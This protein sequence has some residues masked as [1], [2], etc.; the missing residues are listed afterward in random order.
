MLPTPHDRQAESESVQ[1][2]ITAMIREAETQAALV[3]AFLHDSGFKPRGK[4]R[5]TSLVTKIPAGPAADFLLELG[6]ALRLRT[7]EQAGLRSA[8]Q[9]DVPSA[10]QALTEAAQRAVARE[11]DSRGSREFPQAIFRMVDRQLSRTTLGGR[12]VPM[13][14]P[15]A[16]DMNRLLNRLADFL[17]EHRSLSENTP[18]QQDQN[19]DL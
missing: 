18:N 15:K 4:I 9:A 12:N 8:L 14:L 19:Y 17:W 6:A 10:D 16:Y 13:V 3:A 5:S 2:I 11:H 7:L 1:R